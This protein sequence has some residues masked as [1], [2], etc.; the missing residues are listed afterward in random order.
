M[1][2]F[3]Q[4]IGVFVIVF[5]LSQCTV[6]K[7]YR[8]I[9]SLQRENFVSAEKRTPRL[10]Y[11]NSIPVVYLY[12]TPREMGLQYGTLL[13]KQLNSL[14][15][16]I[17]E[18]FPKSV[19]RKY[20]GIGKAAGKHLP[21]R[22]NEELKGI[23]EASGVDY[24][25]LLAL[26]MA[27]RT[28]CS[29]LAV[30]GKATP[31]GELIMGRNA[32]YEFK[33]I[34]KA[35]GLIVIKHPTTGYSTFSISFLGLMGSYTG[36]NETGLSYGNMLVHNSKDPLIS[37][38]GMPVQLL[39]QLAGEQYNNAHDMASFLSE[40]THETPVNVMCADSNEA[41]V[42]ELSHTA[43]NLRYGQKGVLAATNFFLSP[44]L[45]K[46]YEPCDRFA[47]LMLSAKEHYGQFSVENMKEAMYRARRKGENLQCILFE[48]AKQKLYVSIN[49][50][51]A[52]K[53]PFTEFDLK[54]MLKN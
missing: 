44:G 17:D 30:W 26:N 50:V 32:D 12:G 24:F 43:G 15:T 48:P 36:M 51:P 18:L 2:K 16:L 1:N 35:L 3:S 27:P 45:Y 7:S 31:N 19:I 41:I 40:Q 49:K 47:T 23:A 20:M 52:S 38:D 4:L 42:V 13:K 10:E 14:A 28:T 33:S 25:K 9:V 5:F 34:N 29:A 54:K 6:Y 11:I 8:D 53:G 39:M 46:K 21:E 22:F 37:T